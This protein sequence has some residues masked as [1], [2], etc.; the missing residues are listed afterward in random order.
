L[1]SLPDT[2]HPERLLN[3][4]V[5]CMI[6]STPCTGVPALL[7]IVVC[8]PAHGEKRNSVCSAH[9]DEIRAMIRQGAQ[10]D[11]EDCHRYPLPYRL[12]GY[13]RESYAGLLRTRDTV[14]LSAR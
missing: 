9:I 13:A 10:F 3:P 14:P 1:H 8:C 4:R 7:D 5:E 2:A 11:C 12:E 6:R